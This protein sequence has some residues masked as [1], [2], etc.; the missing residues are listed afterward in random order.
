MLFSFF[1]YLGRFEENT[2]AYHGKVLDE[3][4]DED[5]A[6]KDTDA[7]NEENENSTTSSTLCT[8]DKEI[9]SKE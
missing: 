3:D 9:D 5:E 1:Y 7:E 2:K 4:E 6:T 8:T